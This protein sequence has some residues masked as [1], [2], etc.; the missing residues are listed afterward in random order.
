MV[1]L[2]NYHLTFDD[3]FSSVSLDTA[4]WNVWSNKEHSGYSADQMV[5]ANVSVSN[6]ALHLKVAKGGTT[7]GRPY[8]SSMVDTSGKF[9]QQYGYMEASLK[10]PSGSGIWPAFWT[11]P[12]NG[13][14]THEIDIMEQFRAQATINNTTLHYLPTGTD[15][16]VTKAYDAGVDL[17]AGFHTYGMEWT[18]NSVTWYIDG[19][20]EFTTSTSVPTESMFMVL[21]NDTD[22]VRSWN[23]VTPSTAFPNYMDVDYVRA[24]ALN[25]TPPPPPSNSPHT[26]AL[27]LS[28]DAWKG[29]ARFT[30]RV[31][32][33]AIGSD[34]P[35]AASHTL[36]QTQEFD[37]QGAWAAGQHNIEIDLTNDK[38]N[39][40]PTKD[41]NL[42]AEKVIY[43][44]TNYLGSEAGIYNNT[45]P[46]HVIVG[47]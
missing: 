25:T 42:Y 34:I 4:K 17:S 1:D 47:S 18:P 41:R 10:V 40:S 15:Q 2:S 5:A 26:L 3:E 38:Y 8:S 21:N 22:P 20:Q 31:D 9:A 32:G 43:D 37:F 7:D 46:L 13:Q 35:V 16:Y 27:L 28:E 36:G 24:Y 33:A 44:G 12:Q 30:V 45:T 14:W 19:V 6:G 39:G 11:F 29:D 23:P